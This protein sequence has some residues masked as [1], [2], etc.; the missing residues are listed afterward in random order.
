[1]QNEATAK[2]DFKILDKAIS[3]M[4]ELDGDAYYKKLDNVKIVLANMIR[5]IDLSILKPKQILKICGWVQSY[6]P[7]ALHSFLIYCERYSH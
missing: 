4:L 1:M 7:M 5:N 6:R 3:E 2:H